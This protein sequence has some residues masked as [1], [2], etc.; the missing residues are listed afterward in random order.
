MN[1]DDDD[2]LAAVV[3]VPKEEADDAE[4]DAAEGESSPS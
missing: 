1:L 3:R 2:T 4:G